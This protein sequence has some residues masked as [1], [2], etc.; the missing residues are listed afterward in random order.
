MTPTIVRTRLSRGILA[1]G[2]SFA[3][4]ATACSGSPT[5]AASGI[6]AMF[7]SNRWRMSSGSMGWLLGRCR[8]RSGERF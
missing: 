5:R 1:I 3:L 4:L 2:V 8:A 6:A 7:S